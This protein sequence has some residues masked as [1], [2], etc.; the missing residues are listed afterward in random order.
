MT[1]VQIEAGD[2][3]ASLADRIVSG[4]L[5]PYGEVGNTNL[6]R[7]SIDGPGHITIPSDVS[8][9][10][11]NE[12]HSQ[13]E[14]RARFLTA[15]DTSA[16]IV[17]SFKIGENPEG[18]TLLAA[19]ESGRKSGKPKRLSVEV[20]G[21]VIRAGKA[22]GG[23]LTGAAFVDKGAFPSAALMAADVGDEPAEDDPAGRS[24]DPEDVV[25]K[26]SAE[27]TGEDGI[28]RKATTTKTTHVEGDKTTI[29]EKTVF[30]EP[31]TPAPEE[32]NNVG[33]ATVPG[34]LQATAPT[35]KK[36]DT[37]DKNALFAMIA[38]A[39]KTGDPGL[40][41]AFQDVKISGANQVGSAAVVPEYVG[42]VW[43]GKRFQRRVIPLLGSATLTSL[44][45]KGYRFKTMPEVSEWAGN[46]ANVPSSN[47][48]TEEVTWGITRFAGGWDIAREFFDFGE[49]A[50]IDAFLRLAADS[51][52]KKSDAKVLTDLL[53][54]ATAAPVGVI[55]TDVNPAI[56]KIVRGALRVITADATPSYALVAPDVFEQVMFTKKDDVLAYLSMSLGLEEG[57]VESFKIVPHLGLAAGSVLVGDKLAASAAELGGSPIRVSAV[58]IVKGGIDEALFGYIQTRVEYPTGLQLVTD[59]A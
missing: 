54:A 25:E 34:S 17:A 29:T 20:K 8:V 5:L 1:D 48:E 10:M 57:Q 27:V 13:L 38:T 46:K 55:P 53:A 6:G 47:G 12:N 51:Y 4:L 49:T 56:V 26:Y 58:D 14:P 9:L 50:V 32:E 3:T 11:A 15:T 33:N 24:E 19:I 36:E 42:E 40:F 18:D 28:T 43:N 39:A 23:Q 16:G 2:L 44:S 31:E 35:K 30:E 22:I 45:T 7:F 21:I 41:A 59:N 37:M 52:A